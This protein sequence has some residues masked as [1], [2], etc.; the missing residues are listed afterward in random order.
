MQF[1]TRQKYT[2]PPNN[3]LLLITFF[4]NYFIF[5]VLYLLKKVN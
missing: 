1:F 3:R 4:A 5:S 2:Y